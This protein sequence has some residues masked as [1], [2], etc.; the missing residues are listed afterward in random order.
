MAM[1]PRDRLAPAAAALAWALFVAG[2]L[3]LGALG[4]STTALWFAGLG[5]VAAWLAV[6]GATTAFTRRGAPSRT[7]VV[8]AAVVVV[9]ALAA[10]VRTGSGPALFVA[11]AGWGVLTCAASS[12]A[13]AALAPGCAVSDLSLADPA[14]WPALAARWAMLPMMAAMAVASDLCARL[15]VTA[16][17]GVA[18]HLVAMTAPALLWRRLRS[19]W[20]VV[21]FMAAGLA[22]LP[23]LPGLR[24]WMAMSL[25]H[26]MAWGVAWAQEIAVGRGAAGARVRVPRARERRSTR[27]AIAPAAAVL[28]LGATI[29]TFGVDGL[30]AVHVGLGVLSLAGAAGWV[31]AGAWHHGH[32]RPQHEEMLS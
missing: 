3:V 7:T 32:V 31:I 16:G 25:L 21:G 27:A 26:A 5:P 28:A 22:A 19:P 17:E 12:R 13:D 30:V 9:T 1:R 2:W 8:G 11:A 18:L 23:A 24:G 20:W 10:C 6:A 15:G 4:Q 29:A 14:R